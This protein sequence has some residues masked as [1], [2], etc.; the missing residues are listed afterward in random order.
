MTRLFFDI[1]TTEITD[2]A[3]LS[4]DIKVHC[5]SMYDP[6]KPEMSTFSGDSINRGIQKL[7]Q[8]DEIIG[9]N[10]IGFDIPV[11]KKLYKFAPRGK[12]YDTLVMAR[13]ECPDIMA[14]DLRD[15]KYHNKE[16]DP[17]NPDEIL[18]TPKR[19]YG[20]HSLE[21]WGYRLGVF[22]GEYGKEEGAWDSFN[23]DMR[24]YCELDVMVTFALW[25]FLHEEC[26]I[27]DEVRWIEHAF[28]NLIRQQ[29]MRGFAFDERKA[30]QLIAKLMSKRGKIKDE[31][32]SMFK[33]TVENMKSAAGWKIQVKDK[34]GKELELE[35]ETKAKLKLLL[36]D[37]GMKQVLVNSAEKTGNK[38]KIIPFN[39]SSRQQIA[40]RLM[41]L[42]WKPKMFHS[43]GVTPK[44]DEPIL[45]EIKHPCAEKLLEYLLVTKRLGHLAEGKQGWINNVKDG[46]IHGKV[47]TNGAVTGRCTHSHPNIAQVPAVRAEY[48]AECRELFKAGDGYVLA[49]TDASGLELRCLA[50]YLSYYDGGDYAHQLVQGDIH[51]INQEA[52]GLNDRDQAKT[53]IYA[54]LYGAGDAKIGNIVNGSASDGRELK[55]RFLNSIPALKRLK[56]QIEVRVKKTGVLR[57]I[58]G[59]RLPIRSEHAAL[60]TLLQS[61]G[62]VVMKTALINLYRSLSSLG[63]VLGREWA[64]VANIHDEF[65][66]E[67]KPEL[68]EVYKHRSVQAIVD[69]GGE[70]G[71]KCPLDGLCII[72]NNWKETH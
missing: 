68:A 53:F 23:D 7:E 72:G 6:E 42:G 5:I 33:P 13:V 46:R 55:E 24:N 63:W 47:N 58:D 17:D 14:D 27:P 70:L 69:A 65:Q 8:A 64:F 39:P 41:Q 61:C 40:E 48:G 10:V 25:M 36:K 15:N 49:G 35:A 51:T 56:Q 30:E 1:E 38:Q 32:Q 71:M 57:G 34:D 4:D 31:L 12:V 54:F 62:A 37:N 26:S 19:L 22:K 16:A 3:R 66:A 50:H 44:I 28:A 21:A 11:L 20:S 43:D 60:N 67:I 18:P 45:K 29:E 52:A 59:R 2:F 9:H